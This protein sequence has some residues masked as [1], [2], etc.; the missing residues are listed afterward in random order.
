MSYG[1]IS[2]SEN[3]M[4]SRDVISRMD[5]L[6]EIIADADP[7]D[8]QDAADELAILQ[9]ATD[10]EQVIAA[11]DRWATAE[12]IIR[13]LAGEDAPVVSGG[14]YTDY[15]ALCWHD[16]P[17]GK[18]GEHPVAGFAVCPRHP[19]DQGRHAVGSTAYCGE[20]R[21]AVMSDSLGHLSGPEHHCEGCAWRMAREWVAGM[22][23][24]REGS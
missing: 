16:V 23:A 3:I 6:R 10:P 9:G 1:D 5:D 4:D 17:Y 20:A 2:N 19:D 15:C 13:E 24:A 21:V 8:K 18:T 11:I 22:D 12:R 7:D 14:S